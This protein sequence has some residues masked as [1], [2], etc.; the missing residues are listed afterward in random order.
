MPLLLHP[1]HPCPYKESRPSVQAA[2]RPSMVRDQR[3]WE[4]Q[5]LGD[6][7]GEPREAS[8]A[9][10]S[11]H[12]RRESPVPRFTTW[13]C[14]RTAQGF[15]TPIA[16]CSTLRCQFLEIARWRHPATSGFNVLPAHQ[17]RRGRMDSGS[18]TK[19]TG[20]RGGSRHGRPA[21]RSHPSNSWVAEGS[22]SSVVRR[23]SIRMRNSTLPRR[24]V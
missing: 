13:A 23:G 18:G 3:P 14:E 17:S 11:L 16:G 12:D 9:D 22:W 15:G 8:I 6:D 10:R 24:R 2:P 7:P 20:N 4:F 1:S 21:D 5:A 19:K